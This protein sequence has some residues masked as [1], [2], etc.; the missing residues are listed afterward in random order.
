LLLKNLNPQAVQRRLN[1]VLVRRSYQSL[2]PN[3]IWHCDGYDKLKPFG[4]AMHG[5]IDGFSRKILWLHCSTTNNDPEVILSY[6]LDT[7]SRVS[8]CPTLVRSDCGTETGLVA[9][10]Q[11]SLRNSDRYTTILFPRLL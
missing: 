11:C 2:G 8:G 1:G 5:C 4:F 7:V 10:A 3:H 9:A 6:F